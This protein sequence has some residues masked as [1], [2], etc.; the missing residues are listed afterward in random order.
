MGAAFAGGSSE[1][2]TPRAARRGERVGFDALRMTHRH[3][4]NDALD[5]I[6]RQQ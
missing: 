5:A 4:A 1:A 6:Q 2:E 3:Y